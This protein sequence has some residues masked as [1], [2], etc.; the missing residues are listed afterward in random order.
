[1]SEARL[2]CVAVQPARYSVD[3][4]TDKGRSIHSRFLADW[5]EEPTRLDYGSVLRSVAGKARRLMRAGHHRRAGSVPLLMECSP[6]T[7]PL[8]Y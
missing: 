2:P 6:S 3:L 5:R 1:M 8:R 4:T 7:T